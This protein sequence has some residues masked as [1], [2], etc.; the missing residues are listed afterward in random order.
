MDLFTSEQ[1]Q[2]L[3]IVAVITT[4]VVSAINT[5]QT[6]IGGKW[7]TAIIALVITLLRTTFTASMSFADWQGTLTNILLT[8]AFAIL[9]WTYLGQYTVDKIF[10]WLKKKIA[11]KYGTANNTAGGAGG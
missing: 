10:S 6:A 5:Y 3:L 9:F 7:L 4:F 8:T 2:A 1:L 11:E